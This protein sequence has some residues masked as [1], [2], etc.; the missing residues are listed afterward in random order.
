MKVKSRLSKKLGNAR[1]LEIKEALDNII[2]LLEEDRKSIYSKRREEPTKVP[3]YDR[4][5]AFLA[6]EEKRLNTIIE[7]LTITGE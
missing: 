4:Q 3:N 5:Q 6:G 2:E 1:A 7:L